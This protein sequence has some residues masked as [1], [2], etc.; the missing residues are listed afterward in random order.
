MP[1]FTTH[2]LFGVDTYHE[3]KDKQLKQVLRRQRQAF[4]LGLQGPDIFFYDIPYFVLYQKSLG[5]IAQAENTGAFF[6]Y[7]MESRILFLSHPICLEIADAYICG[8]IGHYTLD[9]ICHPYVY[10][11]TKYDPPHPQKDSQYFGQHASLEVELDNAL[12]MAKKHLYPSEFHQEATIHLNL[13]QQKVIGEMLS[14]AF[15]HTYPSLIINEGLMHQAFRFAKIGTRFLRDPKGK[16]KVVAR[17]WEKLIFHRPYLSAMVPS[18][19]QYFVYDPLNKSHHPW[20][21]PWTGESSD[22]SFLEL[23]QT[24][25]ELYE[26]RLQNYGVLLRHAS[27]TGALSSDSVARFCQEYG[28][29]SFLSGLSLG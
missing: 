25:M 11:R 16:K 2:Y 17:F 6:S 1:G 18:D 13:L 7:L 26:K 29:R 19:G 23:Y 22:A 10:A 4:C 8:F 5:A 15:R 28:N 3:L 27:D 21:H 12:L 20:I 24:A 9:C 14:Y